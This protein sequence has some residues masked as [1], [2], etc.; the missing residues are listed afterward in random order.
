MNKKTSRQAKL[1]A[2]IAAE[3]KANSQRQIRELEAAKSKKRIEE[4]KRDL[5]RKML[6]QSEKEEAQ[7]QA[8]AEFKRIKPTAKSRKKPAD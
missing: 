6:L 3:R 2:A 5:L 8:E 1:D 4:G 7:R